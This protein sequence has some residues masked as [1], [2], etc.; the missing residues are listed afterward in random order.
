MADILCLDTERETVWALSNA[1]HRV[2]AAPFGYGDG[3]RLL[4]DPPHD[5]DL[6]LCDLRDAAYFD[7]DRWGPY[8]GND[9]FKCTIIRS[10]QFALK[11]SLLNRDP[12]RAAST[13]PRYRLIM[14]TQIEHMNSP[15][16]YGPDDVRQAVAVA[17]VPA[18]IFLNP[19]WVLHTDGHDFPAFVGI[20]WD[21]A[22]ANSS[23]IAVLDPLAQLS[24][25][26]D[27]PLSVVTPV[28]CMLQGGPR[29]PLRVAQGPYLE[30]R[31]IVTDRI[32]SVLGQ[33]VRCGKGA[34]WLLPATSS[35]AQTACQIAARIDSLARPQLLVSDGGLESTEVETP[36][37][38]DAFLCHASEDKGYTDELYAALSDRGVKIWYDK[39]VL[40]IGDRLLS[41]IDDGLRRSSYGV[42]VLSK[43]FFNKNWPKAELDALFGLEMSDGRKRILPI[44]LDLEHSNVEKYSPI[45]ASLLASNSKLGVA[46]NVSDVLAAMNWPN[47]RIVDSREPR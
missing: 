2:V 6:I 9:N 41:K 39:F 17:R 20:D 31:S 7:M 45:L 16:P 42:V 28:R 24:S 46:K 29:I 10:Q 36:M 27:P 47:N 23:K 15:S 34:V 8:G 40:T 43:N 12:K 25:D 11:Q 4:A 5:F 35:N 19:E 22:N 32:D 1:G 38:W 18:V 30:A 26:W 14:E 33:V 13:T 21:T 37:Q 3:G 44:W